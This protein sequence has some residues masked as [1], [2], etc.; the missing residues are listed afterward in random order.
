M[1]ATSKF[2]FYKILPEHKL[3]LETLKGDVEGDDAVD[4][5]LD[6]QAD[7]TYNSEY[8]VLIDLRDVTSNWTEKSEESLNR[9][10]KFMKDNAV[11]L[12]RIKIALLCSTP[13]HS[14]LATF[15]KQQYA[16]FSIHADLYTTP[17]AALENLGV[18]SPSIQKIV[19]VMEELRKKGQ[20]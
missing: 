11:L 7:A 8:S 12:T 4:L 15:L 17:E 9:F 6:L 19:F 1:K 10:V 16:N 5:V 18:Y 20:S 13:M 2:T 3:I 14:I